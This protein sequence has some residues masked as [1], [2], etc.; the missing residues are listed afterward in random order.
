MGDH[1]REKSYYEQSLA[2]DPGDPIA[3]YGLAK[4]AE[5]QGDSESA[6]EFAASCF[7]AIAHSNDEIVKVGLLDLLLVQWPDAADQ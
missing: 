4:V 1:K 2:V 6:R 3:L 7:R 5:A